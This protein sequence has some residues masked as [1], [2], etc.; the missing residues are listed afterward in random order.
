MAKRVEPSDSRPPLIPQRSLVLLITAALCASAVAAAVA[1]S[2]GGTPLVVVTWATA[3]GG[4]LAF[5]H[6]VVD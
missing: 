1:W 6:N 4:S 3:F 5:L 2:G